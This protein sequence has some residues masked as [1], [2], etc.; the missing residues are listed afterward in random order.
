M[1]ILKNVLEEKF[2]VTITDQR[3]KEEI[4]KK[5]LERETLKEFYQLGQLTPPPLYGTEIS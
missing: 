3:L 4:K 1:I 5:N 2:N